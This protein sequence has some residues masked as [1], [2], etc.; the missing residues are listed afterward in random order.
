MKNMMQFFEIFGL[1]Y[2]EFLEFIMTAEAVVDCLSVYFPV[3]VVWD[4]EMSV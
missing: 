4:K 1:W 2:I 3:P